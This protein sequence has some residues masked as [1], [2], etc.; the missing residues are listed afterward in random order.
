MDEE[1]YTY[2]AQQISNDQSGLSV[3]AGF[4]NPSDDAQA[5]SL[6]FNQRLVQHPSGTFI[7]RVRGHDWSR[8]GIWDGDLA[9]VDRLLDPRSSDMVVWCEEN[10]ANFGLSRLKVMPDEATSWG[11]VTAIIHEFRK[12]LHD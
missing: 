3:H 1:T 10:T 4:P 7:F 5:L 2:E 8:F 11:V 12:V 6:D 9:I